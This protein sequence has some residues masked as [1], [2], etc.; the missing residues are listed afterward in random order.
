MSDENIPTSTVNVTRG[1]EV[2]ANEATRGL[3]PGWGG[4]VSAALVW[5]GTDVVRVPEAMGT[6]RA[7]Q[8]QGT[9]R[10]RLV[11]IAGRVCYDSLG[12]GRSSADFHQHLRE[13]HRSPHEAAA[14]TVEFPTMTSRDILPHVVNRPSLWAKGNRITL[15]LRHVLEWGRNY[16]G[17]P[18]SCNDVV[19]GDAFG[20]ALVKIGR[21]I[22][23]QVIQY[24]TLDRDWFPDA[25][26][27][28]PDSDEEKWIS[29]Y[30][31][32]SRGW[33]HEIV[34]HGDWTAISQRSTRY[35]D[36]SESEWVMHPLIAAFMEDNCCHEMN[37]VPEI[38]RTAFPVGQD[39]YRRLVAS[40]E[41]WLVSRGVDKV[42]ARKQARGA[43]RGVLGNALETEV[44]F[45]ASVAQWRHMLRM[46]AAD[47]ADAEIRLQFAEAVLPCLRASR[48]ADRFADLELQPAG[49]GIGRSLKGGGAK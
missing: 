19:L 40:L 34:R 43:A 47:A 36:E 9:A 6:P 41:P 35:V 12:K 8:M 23:P 18:A 7:D 11:E 27:V 24:T 21:E 14:F 16:R 10:E 46:R 26:I 13:L 28:E 44:V 25:R 17:E 39:T 37:E 15:N 29:L 20:G 22:A 1:V 38:L 48:Y 49:D 31:V 33:S 2:V 3:V 30:L 32:G 5:D 4:R 45:S 42:S